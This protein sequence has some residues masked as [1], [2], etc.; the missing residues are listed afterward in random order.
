MMLDSMLKPPDEMKKEVT[1][2]AIAFA[3]LGVIVWIGTTV[4]VIAFS[5]LAEAMTMRLRKALL[6]TV[7]RQ[8]VGYHDD[9]DHTPALIGTALQLWTYRVRTVC[10]EIEAKASV[11]ASVGIGLGMAF[12]GCWQVALAMFATIPVLMLAGAAQMVM[13][14]GGSQ[15][16]NEKIRIAQ[17]IVSDS[18]QNA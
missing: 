13:M 3:V 1:D 8:E 17:Q 16:G 10:A 2:L 5:I 11:F 14:L 4:H 7:F 15:L 18:V 6:T 12:W 9:P